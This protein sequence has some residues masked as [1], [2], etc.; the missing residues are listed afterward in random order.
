MELQELRN[1]NRPLPF[2]S[3]LQDQSHSFHPHRRLNLLESDLYC[4][5][6]PI[7]GA[8]PPSLFGQ[9]E[10]VWRVPSLCTQNG[11]TLLYTRLEF[12]TALIRIWSCLHSC[13]GGK[14]A[15]VEPRNPNLTSPFI[16]SCETTFPCESDLERIFA[17]AG[18]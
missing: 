16:L 1:L 17:N 10:I 5:W 8:G 9:R 18:N 2:L 11:L 6:S 15:E 7:P 4:G 12:D 3:E 14:A 13:A